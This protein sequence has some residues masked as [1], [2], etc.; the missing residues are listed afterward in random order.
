V[1]DYLREELLARQARELGLDEGD[2]IVRRRLAQKMQFLVDDVVRLQE[3]TEQELRRVFDDD[4][5]RFQLPSRLSL[6]HVFFNN[7]ARAAARAS[8]AVEKLR[9]PASTAD[10]AALGDRSLLEPEF[11]DLDEQ[12]VAAVFGPAFARAAFALPAGQWRGPI[13]SGYGLH[14]VQVTARR[15]APAQ[16]F[17]EARAEVLQEWRRQK[18]KA[19]QGQVLA[20]LVKKYGVTAD[21][22][23]KPVV[24][25]IAAVRGG[26][27]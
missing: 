2:A 13:E 1:A 11:H 15:Q 25:Q 7:D 18:E 20:R 23:V 26:E 3:P 12:G 24:D 5:S 8:E 22:A 6:A 17:A 14:L 4:P 19:A 16:G 21:Q 9:S 27:R 10:F